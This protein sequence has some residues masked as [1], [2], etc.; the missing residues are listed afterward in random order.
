MCGLGDAVCYIPTVQVLRE[1][2]PQAL[3]TVLVV[4][5]VARKILDL[6]NCGIDVVVFNRAG[7]HKG[8]RN[9]L[10]FFRKIRSVHYDVVISGAHPNSVRVPLFA[11]LSGAKRRVGARAERY[12]FLYNMPV[13]VNTNA[14]AY[15]RF[16]TLLTAIGINIAS[17]DYRPRLTPPEEGRVPAESLLAANGIEAGDLVIGIASG[18]D[19]NARGIWKPYLKRWPNARYAGLVR[20]LSDEFGAKI[21]MF[22]GA[23]ESNLGA[24]IALLSEVP[25]INLCGK[26]DINVLACLLARCK[27]IVANDTGI[28][29]IASAVETPLVTLFGPTD[30]GSFAPIG[31][32][33]RHI[34]GRIHCSPCYPYPT[35]DL[36]AC[37][38]MDQISVEHVGLS[39]K[40]VLE[41]FFAAD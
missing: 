16:R 24:E 19:T 28:M 32:L 12:S 9:L 7:E 33:H 23:E 26:T 8:W 5:E 30:V 25:I 27:L 29:H 37:G 6:T 3:I 17:E 15:D 36:T 21:L 38:A 20:R 34:Q 31:D 11:A 2:Y 39:V 41:S 18:A 13:N 4:S 10:V 1:R 40:Q 35:C 22:G 14:H